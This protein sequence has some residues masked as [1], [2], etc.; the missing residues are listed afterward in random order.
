[1]ES[2]RENT[3]AFSIIGVTTS[4]NIKRGGFQ[5]LENGG[6][7]DLALALLHSFSKRYH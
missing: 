5:T 7:M 2:A 3:F 6:E 4:K 1:M